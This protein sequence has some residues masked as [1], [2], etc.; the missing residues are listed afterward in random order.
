MMLYRLSA[1]SQ[2]AQPRTG[3]GQVDATGGKGDWGVID[4]WLNA[5]ACP[6][7]EMAYTEGLVGDRVPEE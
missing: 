2:L 3:S 5:V 1:V 4:E 7:Y 6:N